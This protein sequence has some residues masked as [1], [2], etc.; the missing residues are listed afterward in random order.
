MKLKTIICRSL[1]GVFA[2]SATTNYANA[3][4]NIECTGIEADASASILIGAGP[5]LN[6]LEASVSIGERYITTYTHIDAEHANIVQFLANKDELSL[7]LMDE[8]AEELIASV[9][10]LRYYDETNDKSEPLQIGYL[11]INGASPVGITCEGP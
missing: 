9:R 6:A 5:V 2:L 11:H 8:Q 10:I 7:D 1:I 3:T 4:S